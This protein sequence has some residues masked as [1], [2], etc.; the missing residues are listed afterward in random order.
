LTDEPAVVIEPD[1]A[2]DGGEVHAT[3]PVVDGIEGIAGF[4]AVEHGFSKWSEGCF[5]VAQVARIAG[6]FSTALAVANPPRR[7]RR[8]NKYQSPVRSPSKKSSVIAWR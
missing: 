4:A 6:E 5:G 8:P 3:G 2:G 7:S 1:V